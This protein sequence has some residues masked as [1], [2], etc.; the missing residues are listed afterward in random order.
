MA[1]PAACGMEGSCGI[2]RFTL[3]APLGPLVLVKEGGG[4]FSAGTSANDSA[5]ALS[6]M[7]NSTIRLRKYAMMLSRFLSSTAFLIQLF[8]Y[9]KT[10][11]YPAR[12][13]RRLDDLIGC[14]S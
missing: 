4:G 5:N 2:G 6:E 11:R 12:T 9:Q 3:G 13:G 10:N 8:D 14:V 7:P 1:L